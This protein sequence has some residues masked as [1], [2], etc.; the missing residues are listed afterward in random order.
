MPSS[1]TILCQIQSKTQDGGFING[2]GSYMVEPNRSKNFHY[3][4][5]RKQ[6]SV[7]LCDF[8]LAD[9]VLLCGKCVFNRGN[10][11]VSIKL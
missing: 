7:F 11:Y 8:Q 10:M 5:Y 3:G 4:F 1:L 9:H 2:L 6:I